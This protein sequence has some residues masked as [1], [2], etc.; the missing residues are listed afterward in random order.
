VKLN[1]KS[2][3]RN[4]QTPSWIIAIATAITVIIL[5]G[6]RLAWNVWYTVA[7]IG[8]PLLFALAGMLRLIS[9]LLKGCMPRIPQ[10][11]T[12]QKFIWNLLIKL[13]FIGLLA[14][15]VLA[16]SLWTKKLM[17]PAIATIVMEKGNELACKTEDCIVHHI[18]ENSEKA[19][20][21]LA[22]TVTTRTRVYKD[23]LR[24]A[25]DNNYIVFVRGYY[26]SGPCW[27]GLYTL[28]LKANG[29]KDTILL[30]LNAE[31]GMTREGTQMILLTEKERGLVEDFISKNKTQDLFQLL[32]LMLDDASMMAE[33][34]RRS[35][36][37]IEYYE[38]IRNS[39]SN[40]PPQGDEV[41]VSPFGSDFVATRKVCDL[42]L[43]DK[44]GIIGAY[45]DEIR[46]RSI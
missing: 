4:P 40:E 12:L 3:I 20:V 15:V 36:F 44:I 46:R 5:V 35:G 11:S 34:N 8:T 27:R 19:T 10:I 42:S 41:I 25:E 1:L 39:P 24:Q 28:G 38:R 37:Q 6:E 31:D 43:Y 33:L 18:R 45:I 16:G 22:E 2:Y 32:C 30:K 26:E 13:G 23:A 9:F 7:V 17:S 29:Q 14:I 21:A